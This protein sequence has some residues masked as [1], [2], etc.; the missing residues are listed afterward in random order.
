MSK[1]RS[2]MVSFII[3][4]VI[5]VILALVIPPNPDTLHLLHITPGIYKFIVLTLLLPYGLIWFTAFYG[6]EQLRDYAA[7]LSNTTEGRAFR[8]ISLG[9]QVFA[10]GLILST[11]LALLLGAITDMNPG[12]VAAQAIINHYVTLGLALVAFTLIGDGTYILADLV[13]ARRTKRTI[14]WMIASLAIVGLLFARLV[15]Q[16]INR[17]DNPYYLPIVW[18][19]FT[20][21]APYIYTWAIGMIA[22]HDLRMYTNQIR[23]VLYR[24][25][26]R[27]LA[28]GLTI[29]I[30]SSIAIQYV[31]AAFIRRPGAP[32]G[33]ILLIDYGLLAIEAA[34]FAMVAIGSKRLK[35]IEE[36]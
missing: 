11:I 21:V 1:R 4:F 19:L 28:D 15:V 34:G 5:T 10:W 18:L 25:A 13:G 33:A 20:V 29:I 24:Q 27:S 32:L 16:N 3:L 23:G 17:N 7:T 31:T 14:R 26:L 2:A 6:Y 8:K 36:V 9:L 35:K 12:F 30:V 22:T